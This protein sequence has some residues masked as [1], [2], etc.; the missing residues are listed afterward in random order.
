MA[1]S[2]GFSSAKIFYKEDFMM[3]REMYFSILVAIVCLVFCLLLILWIQVMEFKKRANEIIRMYN[4]LERD[5]IIGSKWSEVVNYPSDFYDVKIQTSEEAIEEMAIMISDAI[6][7]FKQQ[8]V[9]VRE[10]TENL[11]LDLYSINRKL[12]IIHDS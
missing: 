10:L 7:C 6:K 4:E 5:L 2:S 3:T 1:L 12:M 11:L 9:F 8:N